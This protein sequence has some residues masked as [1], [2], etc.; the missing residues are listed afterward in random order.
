M[1]FWLI[2][3]VVVCFKGLLNSHSLNEIQTLNGN[4]E[5]WE[6]GGRQNAELFYKGIKCE[7]IFFPPGGGG[8]RNVAF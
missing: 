1:G 7:G 6:G 5:K 2:F 3:F 4:L 8:C